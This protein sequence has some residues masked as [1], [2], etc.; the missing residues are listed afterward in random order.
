[1]MS[2]QLASLLCFILP[3]GRHHSFLNSIPHL[4]SSLSPHQK[5]SE[6]TFGSSKASSD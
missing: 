1:M 3:C 2:E 5:V 6:Q 4:V